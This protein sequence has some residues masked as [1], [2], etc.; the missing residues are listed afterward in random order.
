MFFQV[1]G[2]GPSELVEN[3]LPHHFVND[4]SNAIPII[5]QKFQQKCAPMQGIAVK[6]AHHTSSGTAQEN[7]N[8]KTNKWFYGFKF[9]NGLQYQQNE[10]VHMSLFC[11]E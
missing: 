8:S 4:I 1:I 2:A 9:G 6:N 11:Y 5:E 10:E 7:K 3:C